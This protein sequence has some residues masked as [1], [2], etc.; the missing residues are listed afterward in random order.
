MASICIDREKCKRDYLCAIECPLKIIQKDKNGFPELVESA[1]RSCIDCGHCAAICPHDAIT[2]NNHFQKDYKHILSELKTSEKAVEQLIKSRR[3]IRHYKKDPVSKK[4]ISHL[5][6]IV[7]WSPTASN[8]QPVHWLVIENRET[9]HK[10][11][12]LVVEWL[13]EGGVL[14]G[15]LEAWES[16]YDCILCGAP[17]L[18]IAHAQEKNFSP[19]I[20]CTIATTTFELAASSLG[21]GTCW[22]GIFMMA[23]NTYSPLIEYLNIPNGHNVFSALMFGYPKFQYHRIPTRNEANISWIG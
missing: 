14:P 18:L 17:N 8:V 11:T 12:K 21:V 1:G 6:D 19:V 9:S 4:E 20:D 7:R 10:I 22:A 23:V 2:L 15:I 16:G 5:L 3:S 13:K